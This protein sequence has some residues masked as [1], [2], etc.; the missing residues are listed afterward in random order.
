MKKVFY[1]IVF[2]ALNASLMAQPSKGIES[3]ER[4][5]E[6]FLN[7]K[8]VLA[9]S[10]G[11]SHAMQEYYFKYTV[12]DDGQPI[13]Q[14]DIERLAAIFDE[15][16]PNSQAAYSYNNDNDGVPFYKIVYSREDNYFSKI[17]GNY[18]LSGNCN[19][20]IINF[21]ADQ[22][23]SSYGMIWSEITFKDRNGS[24]FRT[25]DGQL[26]KFYDGVW[27]MKTESF[28]SNYTS[29]WHRHETTSVSKDANV[30][31]EMLLNQVKSLGKLYVDSKQNGDEK[32][33]DAT[34]Y[35]LRNVFY[36]NRGMLT[37]EQFSKISDEIDATVMASE[38]EMKEGSERI[39]II[40]ASMNSMLNPLEIPLSGKVSRLVSVDDQEM[41][42]KPY[43]YRRLQMRFDYGVGERPMVKVSL[44]GKA[45]KSASVTISMAFSNRQPYKVSV[46]DDGKFSFKGVFL[47]GQMLEIED[48]QG[49]KLVV[50]A[51]GKAMDIDLPNKTVKGSQQNER[52][53]ECQRRLS[54]LE[55]EM[56]KYAVQ[57]K[58]RNGFNYWTVVNTD[59]FN[60]LVDDA[61][62]LQMK[63]MKENKDNL[64]PAWFLVKNFYAMTY[65]ELTPFMH[66]GK[67][68]A[69]HVLMQPV[70]QYY[71]GMPKRAVGNKFVD[72]EAVD[73]A[74]VKH[75]LREYIGQGKYTI[76]C[77]WNMSSR[78]DMKTLKELYNTYDN[79]KLNIVCVTLDKD[80]DGWANYVRKRDLRMVHLQPIG[81]ENCWYE[82]ECT[83]L[84]D[85][86][87]NTVLPETIIF[88][89]DGNIM[90]HGLCG[91]A[92]RALIGRLGI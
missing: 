5:F 84:K 61:H 12:P 71:E 57:V 88:D 29:E 52:F 17:T 42:V 24:P 58:D 72:S 28:L 92:L 20:R 70:W 76:L 36:E 86:G 54:A 80:R 47:E 79:S 56:H 64:I 32:T 43:N 33:C 59:G 18:L 83:I 62:N 51:D 63:M 25:I 78:N 35:F 44:T 38:K 65:D 85:Y 34:A 81:I 3:M 75:S 27:K 50:I 30:R 16:V 9:K 40:M 37:T 74:G 48:Q 8:E 4:A 87:V 77:F 39:S 26:F 11:W 1:L 21:V 66:H 89:T 82:W 19:F 23:L 2:L 68:Y 31:Y 60:R 6:Q 10:T 53:A 73:T 69:E 91:D 13:R 22:K 46:D 90:A 7:S 67:P 55:P 41:F 45:L 49:N 14:A 15:N